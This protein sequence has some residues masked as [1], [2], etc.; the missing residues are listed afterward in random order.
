MWSVYVPDGSL[1]FPIPNGA[2]KTGKW[3]L[4]LTAARQNGFH[5]QPS[6]KNFRLAT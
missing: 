5:K 1:N 4:P 6:V 3:T 2:F